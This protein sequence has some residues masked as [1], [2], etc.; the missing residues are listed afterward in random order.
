MHKICFYILLAG[1]SVSA[2]AQYEH[3]VL[4]DC[5][6][7]IHTADDTGVQQ[8]RVEGHSYSARF[9][10]D[11]RTGALVGGINTCNY[12]DPVIKVARTEVKE[13]AVY[14]TRI[15]PRSVKYYARC[16]DSQHGLEHLMQFQF[17]KV[18][19]RLSFFYLHEVVQKSLL[20]VG[21][22]IGSIY[23]EPKEVLCQNGQIAI[24][25]RTDILHTLKMAKSADALQDFL[26]WREIDQLAHPGRSPASLADDILHPLGGEKVGPGY[27]P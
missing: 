15:T 2:K 18:K 20:Q 27:I 5:K 21:P 26:T 16:G 24:P 14:G 8:Y 12:T 17:D 6:I 23:D 10:I 9:N 4:G 19:G 7:G 11:P 3:Y 25:A 13:K 22:N 1:F